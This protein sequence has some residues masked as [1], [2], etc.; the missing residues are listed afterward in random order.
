MDQV[1][2]KPNN[3]VSVVD[4]NSVNSSSQNV[5][6]RELVLTNSTHTDIREL[7]LNQDTNKRGKVR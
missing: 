3:D 4:A 7:S 5:A 1:D 2:D 6:L